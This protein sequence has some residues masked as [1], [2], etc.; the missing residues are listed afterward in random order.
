MGLLFGQVTQ[1]DTM[2]GNPGWSYGLWG[3]GQL[4]LPCDPSKMESKGTG[5]AC[6]QMARDGEHRSF[7]LG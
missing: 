5:R 7:G 2:T 3:E 1:S 6:G 4:G